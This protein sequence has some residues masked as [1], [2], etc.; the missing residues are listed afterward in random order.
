MASVPDKQQVLCRLLAYSE[1]DWPSTSMRKTLFL[2]L[3]AFVSD[4]TGSAEK[5]EA[6]GG[7]HGPRD[8]N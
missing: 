5:Q 2:E 7:S 8:A 4:I 6:H 3:N 1:S